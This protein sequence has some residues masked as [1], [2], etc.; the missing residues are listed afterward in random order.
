M[1]NDIPSEIQALVLGGIFIFIGYSF[2]TIYVPAGVGSTFAHNVGWAFML[3]GGIS[4]V[5]GIWAII[6]RFR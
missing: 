2:L 4:L 6:Q 3:G 5:A 1:S